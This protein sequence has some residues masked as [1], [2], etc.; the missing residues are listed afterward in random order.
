MIYLISFLLTFN[1][2]SNDSL[3]HYNYVTFFSDIIKKYNIEDL[4]SLQDSSK[5]FIRIWFSY[6]DEKGFYSFE[7]SQNRLIV[8]KF[9]LKKDW[10]HNSLAFLG[11]YKPSPEILNCDSVL[12]RNKYNQ[13][14]A[15]G[16]LS[17]KDESELNFKNN[18]LDGIL[19]VIEI[20]KDGFYRNYAYGNPQVFDLPETKKMWKIFN[21]VFKGMKKICD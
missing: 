9:D 11:L 7:R 6:I 8:K 20:R 10:F 19:I 17:L 4:Q 18:T 3:N 14:I 21:I 16:V 12:L 15:Q 2:L 1:V 13:L 5:T